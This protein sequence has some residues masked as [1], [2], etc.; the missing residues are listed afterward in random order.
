MMGIYH[1]ILLGSQQA[2]K[3]RFLSAFTY[4]KTATHLPQ[5]RYLPLS[6]CGGVL[7]GL[8]VGNAAAACSPHAGRLHREPQG[9]SFNVN[10]TRRTGAGFQLFAFHVNETSTCCTIMS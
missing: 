2:R 6:S 10:Q 5:E 4:L 8:L 1:F 3:V 9:A 7:S